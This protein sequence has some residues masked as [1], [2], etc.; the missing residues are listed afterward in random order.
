MSGW[1]EGALGRAERAATA[2]RDAGWARA[3]CLSGFQARAPRPPAGG[4]VLARLRADLAAPRDPDRRGRWE[5]GLSA[6]ARAARGRG[7]IYRN[8]SP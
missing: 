4:A 6:Q 8:P 7:S 3:G 1:V 5:P 2:A